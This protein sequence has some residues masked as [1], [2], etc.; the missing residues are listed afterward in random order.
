MI[1]SCG[2][3]LVADAEQRLEGI[4]TDGDLRRSLQQVCSMR[5]AFVWGG[6]AAPAA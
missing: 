1:H 2:C 6:T 3:V 5:G 4:F